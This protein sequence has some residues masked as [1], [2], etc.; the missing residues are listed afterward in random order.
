MKCPFIVSTVK[1]ITLRGTY[2]IPSFAECLESGCRSYWRE[3]G[4]E[5][6]ALLGDHAWEIP[7]ESKVIE[8]VKGRKIGK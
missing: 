2:E 8:L 3:G 7:Q 4:L 6:C 5:G 1:R